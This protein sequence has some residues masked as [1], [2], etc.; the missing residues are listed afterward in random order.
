MLGSMLKSGLSVTLLRAVNVLLGFAVLLILA[1][2]LGPESLGAYAYATTMLLLLGIPVSYGWAPLLLREA[3]RALN[4]G[5]WASVKG[6][7]RRGMAWTGALAILALLLGLLAAWTGPAGWPKIV[8]TS[9]VLLLAVVLFFDQL[10]AL[11]L[12]LLRGLGHDVGGQLREM[13][14]RPSVQLLL[15]LIILVFGIETET[16]ELPLIVLG[17]AAVVS[18][19]SGAWLLRRRAPSRL[20]AVQAQYRDGEWMKAAGV[21]STSAGLT[22]LNGSTDILLLGLLRPLAE[23]G[24]YKVAVQISL[25]GALAYTSLNMIA[26]QRFAMAY[27]ASDLVAVQRTA[28][29][30]ARLSVLAALPLVAILY[31]GGEPL[32]TLLFGP[33]FAPALVP[34]V[35]LAAGQVVNAA[36]G[37]GRSMLMA[38]GDEARVMR[39]AAVALAV[40]FLSCL[41]LIPAFGAA[42][43]AV[44]NVVA[45]IAWNAMLWWVAWRQHGVDTS[46]LGWT[47]QANRAE[48]QQSDHK[49]SE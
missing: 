7:A 38:W 3:A 10:S 48:P 14:V 6:M 42:G 37:M 25:A 4:D 8:T 35:I 27:A 31:F 15:L 2:I 24:Q 22:L 16:L 5:N 23:V 46:F 30:A 49:Q 29:V 40:K 11:R 32:I 19:M 36:S 26:V 17:A 41:L 28:T 18:F 33:E 44:A 21:L 45:L 47:P 13:L 43:A 20:A 39:C 1:R 12:A 34:M 9:T